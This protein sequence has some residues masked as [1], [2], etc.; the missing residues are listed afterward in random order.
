MAKNNAKTRLLAYFKKNIGK[1]I[2]NSELTKIAQVSDWPRVCRT[3]RQEGWKLEAIQEGNSHFY[4]LHSDKKG[5]GNKRVHISKKLRYEI[6]RRDGF[7]CV[8]CGKSAEE[9]GVKLEIDHK[10]PV[11]MG[12]LTDYSNLQTLCRLCNQGKKD[13][14]SQFE[15]DERVIEVLTQTSGLGRLRKIGELFKGEALN[16]RFLETFAGI[17]DWPRSLRK[18]RENDELDYEWDSQNKLYR[19]K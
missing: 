1:K 14:F 9:D 4:I 5:K 12:G 11:N 8:Q 19:F 15:E 17:R 16:P 3:L 13:Y 2:P 7:R 10:I 18:L 6:L